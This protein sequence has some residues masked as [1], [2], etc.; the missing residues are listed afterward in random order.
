MIKSS[1]KYTFNRE[2]HS[3]GKFHH[4]TDQHRTRSCIRR[5]GSRHGWRR[6]QDSR[7]SCC[8]SYE[9]YA[10]LS[11]SFAPCF[12]LHLKNLPQAIRKPRRVA[13]IVHDVSALITELLLVAIGISEFSNAGQRIVTSGNWVLMLMLVSSGE[14]DLT[15][16]GRLVTYLST[17]KPN[18]EPACAVTLLNSSNQ[19]SIDC[20][21]SNCNNLKLHFEWRGLYDDLECFVVSFRRSRTDISKP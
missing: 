9:C 18:T 19:C 20:R 12:W 21:S 17:S 11:Q 8:H 13:V 1:Y 16:F 10:K 6:S 14:S 2:F 4:P 5:R 3:P 15:Q 7:P